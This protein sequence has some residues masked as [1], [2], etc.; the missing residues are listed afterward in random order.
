MKQKLL[1]KKLLKK[2]QLKQERLAKEWLEKERLEKERLYE[3]YQEK[4]L[5]EEKQRE[6][7]RLN[8]EQL[9]QD[10]LNEGRFEKDRLERMQLTRKQLEEDAKLIEIKTPKKKIVV[11]KKAVKE[12]V[13]DSKKQAQEEIKNNTQNLGLWAFSFS[14]AFG[15]FSEAQYS[16]V[17]KRSH[18]QDAGLTNQDY[19]K[20]FRLFELAWLEFENNKDDELWQESLEKASHSP[21]LEKQRLNDYAKAVYILSKAIKLEF[22]ELNKLPLKPV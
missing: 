12:K 19:D 10:L 4:E 11:K 9:E 16:Y 1:E 8:Q 3:E 6:K 2:K 21:F 14:S 7:L 17:N 5:L 13:P 18:Y 15:D 20:K 22:D